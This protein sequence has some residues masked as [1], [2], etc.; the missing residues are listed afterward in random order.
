MDDDARELSV[1]TSVPRSGLTTQVSTPA[2]RVSTP[3]TRVSTPA[4]QSDTP[5]ISAAGSDPF[6]EQILSQLGIAFHLTDRSDRGLLVAYQKYK[7]YLQACR[8]YETK[9]ADGSW[10]GNKLTAVDLIQL[11]VSRSFWHSHYRKLFPKVSNYPDM[12]AWLENS[13]DRPADIVVWGM[14]KSVYHFKDL[15]AFLE[16]KEK[17]GKSKAKEEK[18]GNEGSSKKKKKNDD[19]DGKKKTGNRKQV[20]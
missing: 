10:I 12:L 5:N 9:V 11:F 19:K 13:S 2:T 7:A 20:K 14:E 4:T 6:K 18:R 3:A 16:R 8:T 17:K 1:P 15:E